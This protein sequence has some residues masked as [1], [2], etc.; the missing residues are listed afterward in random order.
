VTSSPTAELAR[1]T[2]KLSYDALPSRV[3][4]RI[5]DYLLDAVASSLA[6]THGDETAQIRDLAVTLGNGTS[7]VI[8][9]ERM[10]MAGAALMNGY[11]IT[12][13][14][15][16][17][18]HRSTLFHVTPEV[19]PPAL[20]VGDMKD[21]GG[22]DLIVAL[23]AGLEVATR[24]AVG[25][26][27]Q[28]FRARGWHSP[29][30]VGPF[31]GAAAAGR[32][33]GLSESLQRNAF[34]LAGSQSAGT[35]AQWGTPTIKFH[36]ARGSLSGLLAALLAQT[37]F[38]ASEEIL[39]HPDGGIYNAYS[40]G[41][42]AAVVVEGLGD[43]WELENI[44]LRLWPLGSSIQSVVT[45]VLNLANENDLRPEDVQR[46]RVGLSDTVYRMHGTMSWD[47]RFKALL[48][49]PYAAGVVLHDRR[50]WLDQFTPERIA[51]PDLDRFIRERIT[52]ENDPDVVGTG[53]AVIIETRSGEVYVDRRAVPKG[54]VADP[55]TREE[56]VEKFH[57]ASR[58][59]LPD[60]EADRAL[61]MILDLE[62][63]S[64][65][66]LMSTLTVSEALVAA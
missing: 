34:G 3:R 50:C 19:V 20:A 46:I 18:V 31:G 35:F 42:N 58:G 16:C 63:S 43:R 44:S 49:A 10:S 48:S 65:R 4:E 26:N 15:V 29:G 30:V 12:A 13:V 1:F 47:D 27:Y 5:K 39:T 66:E 41:G 57:T 38:P 7:A 9:G 33:L 45:A 51:D 32:L 56:I 21:S 60:D 14:T 24:V 36:Q 52:V 25:T 6:G 37:G 2:T 55:L 22:K 54:D 64:V 11:L 59:I 61:A 23:A 40:D 8:G 62:N 53:A 17:D 28:A